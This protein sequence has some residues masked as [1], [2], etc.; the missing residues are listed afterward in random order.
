MT[1]EAEGQDTGAE[2]SGAAGSTAATALAL[3]G[4]SREEADNFLRNQ[5]GLIAD[6]RHHLHRQLTALDLGI[7][8][9]RIGV[10]LRIATAFIGIVIAAGLAAII[11]NAAHADGLVIES[12][13]VPPDLA[14]QGLTGEVVASQMLDRLSDMNATPSTRAPQSY[15][16]NWG[17]DLKVEIP[18][19]GISVGEAYRF[20]KS[21]LGH[22]TRISGELWHT[23][24]GIA[25]TA[26]ITGG[27][28]ATV[29]G[30][31]ADFGALVQK[32]A[33]GIYG[34]T[35][36][37]RYALYLT[38]QG[39]RDEALTRFKS[40]AQTGAASDRG[41]AYVGWNNAIADS[42]P[43]SER[44]Q[45]L[46][47]AVPY[48]VPVAVSNLAV[49]ETGRGRDEQALTYYKEAESLARD[50]GGDINPATLTGYLKGIEAYRLSLLGAY[51][52]AVAS[53]KAAID[54]GVA[55]T[56]SPSNALARYEI[57]EH[58]L[59][60]ARASVTNPVV[61]L[62]TAQAALST[63]P[64]RFDMNMAWELQDWTSFVSQAAALAPTM[65][66]YPGLESQ[67]STPLQPQLAYAQ[68]KLGNFAEAEALI[69]HTPSD[70]YPCLR[71]RAQIAELEGQHRRAD[72]WFARAAAAG[73]DFPFADAEWGEVLL[74]RGQP[75][76]ANE[77]F[78]LANKKSPQY[79]DAIEM[80][81]EA[82]MKKNR[83]DLALAKFTEADKYAPNWGRLHLKWGE[84]LG[85][86]GR[87]DEAQKQFG[88]A[89]GLDLSSA[90]NAEL[91]KVR[92]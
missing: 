18:D 43:S 44:E 70:C 20:L 89:A 23:A 24:N 58:D 54:A 73:P 75:D 22:E 49:A 47:Q 81:G 6:Q 74:E 25:I 36:P 13:S 55:T 11:W 59:A 3:G 65:A 40:L 19:T 76:A 68:A 5:N 63:A 9:K 69:T 50:G 7:W 41:W 4:A 83:S 66:K 48:R 17:D 56:G 16:N 1:E 28:A 8:E 90:D 62:G 84:A 15:A 37:Y 64:A 77:K 71:L 2:A 86:T 46:L 92:G 88:L 60:G 42:A 14:A 29:D 27:S 67:M 31:T 53:E 87:K 39:R 26:R 32:A 79:A 45:L 10:L 51:H 52:A 30:S 61:S 78:K 38:V 85:Y 80:W 33:E 21:W 35:Q 91:A 34:R 12:F 57:G 82:L 72:Y